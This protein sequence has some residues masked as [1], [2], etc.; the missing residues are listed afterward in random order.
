V[1]IGLVLAAVGTSVTGQLLLKL[2]ASTP[3]HS[4]ADLVSILL[5]PYTLVALVFYAVSAILWIMVLSRVPLSYAYPLLA[6]NYVL[7]VAV[8]AW[9]LGE[10]VSAQRWVGVGVIMLGFLIAATS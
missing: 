9:F 5:K 8:S 7:V 3:V 10:A 4:P 2:G 1:T 6:L